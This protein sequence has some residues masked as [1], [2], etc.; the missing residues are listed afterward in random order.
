MQIVVNRGMLAI[1]GRQQKLRRNHGVVS[2]SEPPE[3]AIL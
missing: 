2:P 3:G 1:A